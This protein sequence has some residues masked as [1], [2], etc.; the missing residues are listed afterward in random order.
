MA[1]SSSQ[2]MAAGTRGYGHAGESTAGDRD[3]H[4]SFSPKGA[5]T[6]FA[7]LILMYTFMW[8]SIYFELIN[9]I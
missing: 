1:L 2:H 4:D 7:L 3:E 9:R 6:F 5:I 8:F